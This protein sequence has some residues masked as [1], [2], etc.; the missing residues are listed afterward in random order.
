MFEKIKNC[1]DVRCGDKFIDVKRHKIVAVMGNYPIQHHLHVVNTED[2]M[3]D[4][5]MSYSQAHD[6]LRILRL[7]N[8]EIRALLCQSMLEFIELMLYSND[9]KGGERK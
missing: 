2:E 9:L 7:S 4:Y 6:S 5:M 1:H 3:D 8:V